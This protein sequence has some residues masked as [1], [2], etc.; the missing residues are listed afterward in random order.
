MRRLGRAF[1]LSVLVLAVV[2]FGVN[3]LNAICGIPGIVAASA[4]AGG[5]GVVI[6]F[7]PVAPF[8]F[9]GMSSVPFGGVAADR[10]YELWVTAVS[11]VP[12]N[13]LSII[14]PAPAACGVCAMAPGPYPNC[15]GPT[16]TLI[17][18]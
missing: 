10:Q 12:A 9:T 13:F 17:F 2:A 8:N 1:V 14:A 15:P 3:D 4:F 18:D 11:D 7:N 5:T 16:I 6:L